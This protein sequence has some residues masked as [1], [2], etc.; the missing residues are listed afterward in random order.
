MEGAQTKA[1]HRWLSAVNRL[2]AA[3]L[4]VRAKYLTRNS[5]REWPAPEGPTPWSDDNRCARMTQTL[6]DRAPYGGLL[7]EAE[8]ENEL[9][10]RASIRLLFHIPICS[11]CCLTSVFHNLICSLC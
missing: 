8:R 10:R 5:F 2:I 9:L 6:Q 3:C 1:W 4:A 11:L 7:T